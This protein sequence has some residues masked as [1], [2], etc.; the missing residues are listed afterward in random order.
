MLIEE[1][2]RRSMRADIAHHR[3]VG[4]LKGRQHAM[5]LPV[6][7]QRNRTNGKTAKKLNRIERRGYSTLS[8]NGSIR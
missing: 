2:L 7:G 8:T 4:T 3:T 6:R 5:G 1:D